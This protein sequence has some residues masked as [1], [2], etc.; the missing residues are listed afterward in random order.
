MIDIHT[1]TTLEMSGL[2]FALFSGIAI[3]DI[4]FTNYVITKKLERLC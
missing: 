4:V 2:M 1:L 3:L